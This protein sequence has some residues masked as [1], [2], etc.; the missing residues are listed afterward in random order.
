MELIEKLAYICK[1][2]N[3]NKAENI[4]YIDT[5]KKSNIVDFFVLATG[6]SVVHV[7]SLI[8]AC[9]NEISKADIFNICFREGLNTSKWQ[10]LDLEDGFVHVFTKE[11]REKYNIEK[12]LIESGNF[13]TYEKLLKK[14][15]STK[16]KND[17]VEKN[18]NLEKE[19][20]KNN[21]SFDD[22]NDKRKKDKIDRALYKISK[23][24]K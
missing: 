23:V 5:S 21:I 16:K 7:K 12:L 4:V 9:Y 18:E 15:S 22:K 3:D 10:V 14:A 2:L 13:M 24:K 19:T 8:D 11:E 20:K 1:I 6:N 17:I